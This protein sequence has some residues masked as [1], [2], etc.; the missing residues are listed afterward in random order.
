MIDEEVDGKMKEI[1]LEIEK[2]YEINFLEIGTDKD[3]VHFLVQSIPTESPSKLI[4]KIKS[5][6]AREMFKWK[7]K[8]KERL[9]GSNFWT[10]GY[11]VNSVGRHGDERKIAKYVE[12]QGRSGE[13]KKLY[14]GQ[15]K[16]FRAKS[17][18]PRC[19]RRG[20]SFRICV[21]PAHQKDC[22]PF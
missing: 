19:L 1:C 2:R 6:I 14:T 11:F 3:H 18:I 17:L 4:T 13:Y 8:L 15:M 16:L 5:L 12:R 7:P 9:W 20:V 10:S 21:S 22:C